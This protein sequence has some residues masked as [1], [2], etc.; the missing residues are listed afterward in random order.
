[1]FISRS[2]YVGRAV[3]NKSE[4]RVRDR[5]P[6]DINIV[7]NML[8]NTRATHVG[9]AVVYKSISNF[10][11]FFCQNYIVFTGML[12]EGQS[13]LLR[14]VFPMTCGSGDKVSETLGFN[15]F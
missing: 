2:A 6:R 7:K 1:M 8:F 13:M 15:N 11:F 12:V 4:S 14:S 3:A 5:P 9:Q 10:F